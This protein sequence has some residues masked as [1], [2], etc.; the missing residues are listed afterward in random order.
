M[1]RHRAGFQKEY[2]KLVGEGLTS[3]MSGEWKNRIRE[4][5]R[6][7]EIIALLKAESATNV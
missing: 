1:E 7:T 3:V 2:L 6:D 5:L 4:L